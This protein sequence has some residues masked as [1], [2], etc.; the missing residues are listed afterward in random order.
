[1]ST[2]DEEILR[3][4][5]PLSR[6]LLSTFKISDEILLK[7]SSK[8]FTLKSEIESLSD[9]SLQSICQLSEE[10]IQEINRQIKNSHKRP[11]IF[12]NLQE[13]EDNYQFI[14]TGSYTLDRTLNGGLEVSRITQMSAEGGSGKTQIWYF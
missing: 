9:S 10:E 2:I 13:M 6:R 5:C 12:T 1:M 4:S 3:K 7:L 11:I 8:G 14:R